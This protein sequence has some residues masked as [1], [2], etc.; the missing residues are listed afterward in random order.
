MVPCM[1]VEC[2]FGGSPVDNGHFRIGQ[3]VGVVVVKGSCGG[4]C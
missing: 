2:S 3:G 4:S 1:A